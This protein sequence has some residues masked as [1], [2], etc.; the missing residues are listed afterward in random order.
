[1]A[2][3]ASLIHK[4]TILNNKQPQQAPINCEDSHLFELKHAPVKPPFG[5][6]ALIPQI[7]GMARAAMAVLAVLAADAV[8]ACI[9][10]AAGR[11]QTP[12]RLPRIVP[13]LVSYIS[14]IV[15]IKKWNEEE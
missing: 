3:S 4:K 15:P 14:A 9:A 1:M 6:R 7:L 5:I 10:A 8:A 12:R 13:M 11:I 2:G